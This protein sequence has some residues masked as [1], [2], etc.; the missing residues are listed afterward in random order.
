[1]EVAYI[2]WDIWILLTAFVVSMYGS[3]TAFQ[4]LDHIHAMEG[5]WRRSMWISISAF[6]MGIVCLWSSHFI[7]R[8]S[9]TLIVRSTGQRLSVRY[10][11]VRMFLVL[12]LA[13]VTCLLSVFCSWG[14]T[15]KKDYSL[16]SSKRRKPLEPL[17][18]TGMHDDHQFLRHLEIDMRQSTAQRGHSWGPA[19]PAHLSR[20]NEVRRQWQYQF[21]NSNDSTNIVQIPSPVTPPFRSPMGDDKT[22]DGTG[23][24]Y[25][26]AEEFLN[27]LYVDDETSQGNFSVTD[28]IGITWPQFRSYLIGGVDS[29]GRCHPGLLQLFIASLIIAAGYTILQYLGRTSLDV[30]FVEIKAVPAILFVTWFTTLLTTFIAADRKSVV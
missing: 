2:E 9:C 16:G 20:D 26:A 17:I 3:T 19:H 11:L 25:E 23:G 4:L 5:A 21:G 28:S 6:V 1:M 8:E 7:A 24:E 30:E 27:D 22:F 13:C 29:K 18:N 15:L 10:G 14:H 12:G